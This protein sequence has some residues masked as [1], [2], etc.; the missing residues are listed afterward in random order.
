MFLAIVHHTQKQAA[1]ICLLCYPETLTQGQEPLCCVR[2]QEIP[3]AP[4]TGL[5]FSYKP[6][7]SNEIP[8]SRNCLYAKSLGYV[9]AGTS[10]PRLQRWRGSGSILPTVAPSIVGSVRA[11]LPT[12]QEHAHSGRLPGCTALADRARN[13]QAVVRF[14]LPF[15]G[16]VTG[17]PGSV[18]KSSRWSRREA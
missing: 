11:T 4:G 2:H 8:A 5:L 9:T 16:G 13:P 17:R 18:S 6:S 1:Q 14:L 10:I 3:P 15:S 12:H 7:V